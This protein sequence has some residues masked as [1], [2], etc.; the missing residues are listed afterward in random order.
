MEIH[1]STSKDP[2]LDNLQQLIDLQRTQDNLS[3]NKIDDDAP[4]DRHSQKSTEV[5]LM[6]QSDQKSSNLKT[7]DVAGQLLH[8]FI[9]GGECRLCFP[10]MRAL[11]LG[12][13]P[14]HLIDDSMNY[15]NI[16]NSSASEDQLKI[17]KQSHVIPQTMARC[18]L[19][20]KTNAER[21]IASNKVQG[22]PSL[23]ENVRNSL[24]SL[25][26]AHDCFG[27]CFA[28]LYPALMP[29]P[30]IE[31]SEC[32][33]MFIPENFCRHSH[34]ASAQR[35][36]CFWGFDASNWPF[37]IHLDSQAS[38]EVSPENNITGT[39]AETSLVNFIREYLT[40]RSA[41]RQIET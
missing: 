24:D 20:T 7:T 22:S 2:L 28:F 33:L 14:I 39:T 34:S 4:V 23:P 17:L 25:K 31:C 26:V 10:Q 8:C 12:D 13:I 3:N 36:H 6:L 1:T 29:D 9:V 35:S 37:Y 16:V 21:L 27:G 38:S 5:P 19:I 15:L 30:C 32:H 40:H 41:R 18:E 11:C